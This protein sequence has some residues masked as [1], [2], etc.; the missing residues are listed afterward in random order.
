MSRRVD[1]VNSLL[2]QELGA[3]ILRE[4]EMPS[5]IFVTIMAVRTSPDLKESKVFVSV[6][7]YHKKMEAL[8]L[9]KRKGRMLHGLLR[10]KLRIKFIPN[11]FF[12][13]DST[14]EE[15]SKIEELL[16]RDV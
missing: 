10:K 15:A 16:E 2:L 6:L 8:N 9:L 4:I 11:L 1:Q 7:P 3:L 12:E 13:I 5:D 14:E